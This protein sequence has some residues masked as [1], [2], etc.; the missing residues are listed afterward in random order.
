[1]P[2]SLLTSSILDYCL[3]HAQ[4]TFY[5]KSYYCFESSVCASTQ[6]CRCTSG[7]LHALYIIRRIASE[8]GLL[9]EQYWIVQ[10]WDVESCC[11]ICNANSRAAHGQW[12][13]HRD[14]RTI[15]M[16]PNTRTLCRNTICSFLHPSFV[17]LLGCKYAE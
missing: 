13:L 16:Q 9:Q 3:H 6:P 12:S 14:T 10:G 1:M 11:I 5:V 2:I 4:N 8:H 15:K 17:C 7:R